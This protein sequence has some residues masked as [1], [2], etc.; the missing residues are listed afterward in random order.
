MSNLRPIH[1]HAE[2]ET[3]YAIKHEYRE[4]AQ[5]GWSQKTHFHIVHGD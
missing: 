4:N 3:R 5:D 1:L 2:N